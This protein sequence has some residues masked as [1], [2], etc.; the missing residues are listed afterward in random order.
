MLF[1]VPDH[2]IDSVKK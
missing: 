1:K 2:L